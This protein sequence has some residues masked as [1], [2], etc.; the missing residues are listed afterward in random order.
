LSSV[1]CRLSKYFSALPSRE[2]LHVGRGFESAET[3]FERTLLATFGQSL[4][5][6]PKS[7]IPKKCGEI[8]SSF[9]HRILSFRFYPRKIAAK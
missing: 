1:K 4:Y 3:G 9:S 7:G 8:I 6:K 5:E 2:Q